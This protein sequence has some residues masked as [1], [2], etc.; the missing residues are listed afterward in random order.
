MDPDNS[1]LLI[2]DRMLPD[3]GVDLGE[4]SFDILMFMNYSA[5]ERSSQQWKDLLSRTGLEL[6]R[7]WRSSGAS[8]CALEVKIRKGN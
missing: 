6:V 1:T 2:V 5:M 7:V 8:E 3:Q 4:A